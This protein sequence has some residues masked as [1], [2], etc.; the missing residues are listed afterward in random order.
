VT[1]DVTPEYLAKLE[2]HRNDAAKQKREKK[3]RSR[4][5]KVVSL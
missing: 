3:H 5:A 1:S 4:N 2:R